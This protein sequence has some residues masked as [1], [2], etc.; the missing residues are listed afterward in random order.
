[1]ESPAEETAAAPDVAVEDDALAVVQNNLAIEDLTAFEGSS[2]YTIV[3]LDGLIGVV[4]EGTS[5]ASPVGRI[6]A[7]VLHLETGV[8]GVPLASASNCA[9]SSGSTLPGTTP[10]ATLNWE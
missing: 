6:R 10:S 4:V 9:I 8:I 3:D 5:V 7:G 2:V 1:M